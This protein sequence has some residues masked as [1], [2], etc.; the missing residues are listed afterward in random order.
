MSDMNNREFLKAR[1]D[2]IEETD[3]TKGVAQPPVVK[4]I[5]DYQEKIILPQPDQKVIKNDSLFSLISQRKSRREFT[6]D[7][8]TLEELSFLIWSSQGIKKMI[9]RKDVSVGFRTVPSAGCRHPFETYLAVR[10]VNGLKEGLYFFNAEDFSL[11]LLEERNDL[12]EAVSEAN[13]GQQFAGNAPVCFFWSAIP[14]RM[15]WRYSFC[16]SKLILL[17]AGHVCQN[18]YLAAEALGMGT[19]AIAAYDQQ[20]CDELLKLDGQNEFVVY[21]APVG[22][23]KEIKE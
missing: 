5:T 17:D 7:S 12:L 13:L 8:I 18:L 19:C 10:K 23:L 4:Q 14:Y 3:Q 6:E 11:L 1:L 20:K 22:V 9:K 15:E 2:T 16:S 21:V